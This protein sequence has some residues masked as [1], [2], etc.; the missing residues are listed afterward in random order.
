MKIIGE[1]ASKARISLQRSKINV[2]TG[3]VQRAEA[4]QKLGLQSR[5]DV[6]RYAE[7]RGWLK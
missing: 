1:V 6:I 5:I 4:L 2:E 7:R 3:A